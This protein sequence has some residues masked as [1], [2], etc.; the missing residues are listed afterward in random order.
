MGNSASSSKA[1]TSNP[2][3]DDHAKQVTQETAAKKSPCCG[4]HAHAHDVP[5]QAL[6]ESNAPAS[7]EV[8]NGTVDERVVIPDKVLEE[9]SVIE[10]KIEENVSLHNDKEPEEPEEPEESREAED[11]EAVEETPKEI[12]DELAEAI[13]KIE[14]VE[15]ASHFSIAG[16]SLKLDNA[17]DVK[18]IVEEI[19]NLKNLQKVSFVGNTI[20]VEASKAIAA[21]LDLHDNLMDVD[22]SD[23]F[24]GRMKEE[25]PVSV[26]EFGKVLM[27]KKN[28]TRV[29]FSDNAFGPIGAKALVELL[30]G[31]SSL[32]ELILNNNGLGPEGGRII[33]EALIESAESR[34]VSGIPLKKV[35]IGRNRLENGS[36][37]AFAKLLETHNQIEEFGLPQCGIRS[38]G[39]IVLSKGLEHCKNIV[40]VDLQDNTFTTAGSKAFADAIP[41][42]NGIKSLNIGDCMCEAE[43]SELIINAIMGSNSAGSLDNFN[44]QYNEMEEAG[45]LCIA[46]NLSKLSNLRSLMLNGNAFNPKGNAANL[47]KEKLASK[48]EENPNFLDSWSD[49][50]WDDEDA[51]E[52]EDEDQSGFITE[53]ERANLVVESESE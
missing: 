32:Q 48:L 13:Q 7:V 33:A 2:N 3:T 51:S 10:E 6:P 23:C 37:Q 39:I 35:L 50:E 5:K 47:I 42:W 26:T 25:V 49:M 45:A 24:T 15:E 44:F 14:I 28:L 21:A 40:S 8:S 46:E 11:L 36:S 52:E 19:K 29:N 53:N 17:K 22:F 20:G 34:K 30:S 38:E 1:S 16:K 41:A 27:T 4:G 31:S 9:K 43:G 12:V 18:E